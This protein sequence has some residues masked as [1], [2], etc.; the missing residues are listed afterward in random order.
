MIRIIKIE[1]PKRG[2]DTVV[3]RFDDGSSLNAAVYAVSEFGLFTGRELDEAELEE[4][5]TALEGK[6][7][8]AKAAAMIGARPL[9]EFELKKR[10]VEKGISEKDALEAAEWLKDIG[11]LDDGGYASLIA[12]R[13]AAK[14]YGAAKIKDEFF[15]RGIPRE[16]WDEALNE[17]STNEDSIDHFLVLKLKGGAGRKEIRKAAD[18][19]YRRGFS[20]EEIQEALSRYEAGQISEE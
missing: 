11:A 4:L 9:S 14:G 15:K 8:K 16:I 5:K 7:A 6:E 2:S 17:Y 13:Y 18:S 19:L 10:L 3:L 12:R 1:Q 20:W